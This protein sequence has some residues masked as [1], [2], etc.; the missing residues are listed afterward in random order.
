MHHHVVGACG[1]GEV[2][3]LCGGGA[4]VEGAFIDGCAVTRYEINA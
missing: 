1:E 4:E 2:G 3:E